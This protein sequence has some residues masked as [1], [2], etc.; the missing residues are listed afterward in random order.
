MAAATARSLLTA[1]GLNG[2]ALK[3]HGNPNRG[4]ALSSVGRFEFRRE[5]ARDDRNA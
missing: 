1:K 3:Q 5:T 4:I 2:T